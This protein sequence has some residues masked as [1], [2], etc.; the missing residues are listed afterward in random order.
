ML[1]SI[2]CVR[3][4]I[5]GDQ[6]ASSSVDSSVNVIDFKTGKVIYTDTTHDKGDYILPL[7]VLRSCYVSVFYLKNKRKSE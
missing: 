4:N 5:N 2:S 3:W 7:I 1:D 6:L